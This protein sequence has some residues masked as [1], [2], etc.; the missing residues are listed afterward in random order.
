[1]I[2]LNH[3]DVEPCR[4]ACYTVLALSTLQWWR[5]WRFFMLNNHI[6]SSS[7]AAERYNTL[8]HTSKC[9]IVI[10]A[11]KMKKR[12]ARRKYYALAVVRRSQKFSPRR[13]PPEFKHLY[14]QTQFG[15]D[16]CTQFRVIVVTDPQTHTP[17]NTKTH[18]QTGPITIHCA[19]K[20]SA[21]CNNEAYRVSSFFSSLPLMR[22]EYCWMR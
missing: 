14:L 16:R 8:Q 6:T 19:A 5:W 22:G 20:L 17:T 2:T 18:K 10:I 15:E 1:M 3:G 12:S 13:K 4:G 9:F 11:R 21:Q 7:Q